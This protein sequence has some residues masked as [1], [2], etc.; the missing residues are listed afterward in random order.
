MVK[1]LVKGGALQTKL[2]F[3]MRYPKLLVPN[4]QHLQM[5]TQRA[6]VR[7]YCRSSC[8]RTASLSEVGRCKGLVRGGELQTKVLFKLKAVVFQG[9]T[10]R[11]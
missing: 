10:Q 6:S 11:T 8:L 1:D 5:D 4:N 9:D 2:L 7:M 3:K